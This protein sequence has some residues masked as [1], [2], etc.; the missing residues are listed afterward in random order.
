MSETLLGQEYEEN[1]PLGIEAEQD[2][3][4]TE[5]Q[6]IERPWDPESIRVTTKTFSLRHILDLIEENSLDIAPDFQRLQVWK[7]KQKAQLIESILLQIPLPAFYFSED[8]DGYLRVVDGLQRLSTVRDFVRGSEFDGRGFALRQLE[9]LVDVE[10]SR[11]TDLPAPWQRR[12]YNAQ[13][14]AHVIDPATPAPV[15]YDI[16]RRINTGGTPLNAQEIRHCMSKKRSRD[17]LHDCVDTPQFRSA[18]RGALE[19]QRRMIDREVVLR[20][21]AFTR[22]GDYARYRELGPMETLLLRT[23]EELDD[24]RIV[25][26]DDL[27]HLYGAL[28]QGLVNSEIVFGEHAFRK[29]PTYSDTLNP[30]NRALFETWTT[31]LA[32]YTTDMIDRAASEIATNARHR[33][34]NDFQYID[35]ISTS[36]GD[37]RRV[38]MRFNTADSIVQDA[39]R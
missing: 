35:S 11:F 19:K 12:I 1:E 27:H 23:T 13:I 5:F 20:F 31:I 25:S 15:K 9:Y 38:E 17:F 39:L 37:Y 34:S 3:S 18:T 29:W 6:D 14:V 24:P 16:F 30:F 32:G 22:M 2:S 28:M 21:I 7:I 36:T 33:M 4:E 8:A 10:G 26:D